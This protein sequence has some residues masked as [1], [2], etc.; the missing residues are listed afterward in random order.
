MS[1]LT[2]YFVA[3]GHPRGGRKNWSPVG[4]DEQC[5]EP[6]RRS[7][8]DLKWT[9]FRRRPV[10]AGVSHP[11]EDQRNGQVF[12]V[13]HVRRKHGEMRQVQQRLVSQLRTPRKRT[14]SE[15]ARR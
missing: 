3:Q 11:N 13:Q 6:E 7:Q 5:R 1:R 9:I 10:T 14:L 8:A 2:I 12:G 15:N 4:A